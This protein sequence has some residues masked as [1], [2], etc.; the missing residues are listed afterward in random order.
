MFK[1]SKVKHVGYSKFNNCDI[2][3]YED[4]NMDKYAACTEG[5][6]VQCGDTVEIYRDD[7]VNYRGFGTMVMKV[8]P[9]N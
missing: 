2:I 6:V 9:N 4:E 3:I 5:L 8:I 1:I 7:Y